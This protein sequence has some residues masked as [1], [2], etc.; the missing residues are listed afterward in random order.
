MQLKLHPWIA[1]YFHR[2]KWSEADASVLKLNSMAHAYSALH[3]GELTWMFQTDV[4]VIT[5]IL[6]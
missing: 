3:Q 2:H 4:P 1:E 5:D 6:S